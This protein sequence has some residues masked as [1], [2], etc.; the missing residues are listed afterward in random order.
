MPTAQGKRRQQVTAEVVQP[1][2]KAKKQLQLAQVSQPAPSEPDVSA[3]SSS[4]GESS[5]PDGSE[6]TSMSSTAE[7]ELEF[8]DPQDKD[9]TGLQALLQQYLDGREWRCGELVDAI[10]Q[11]A[12]STM[13][14]PN[15]AW[16]GCYTC[17]SG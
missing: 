15:K 11:Q 1:K 17:C 13:S 12:S 6:A 7:C 5:S 14:Q 2:K 16:T 9:W 4:G 8:F 10:I 3:T